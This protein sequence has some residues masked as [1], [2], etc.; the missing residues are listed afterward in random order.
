MR[1]AALAVLAASLPLAPSIFGPASAQVVVPQNSFHAVVNGVF[2]LCPRLVEAKIA[3][4]D[5]LSAGNWGFKPLE[6]LEPGEQRLQGLYTEAVVQLWFE[7]VQK[8]CTVHYGGA[9]YETIAIMVREISTEQLGYTS[10]ITENDRGGKVEILARLSTDGTMRQ[11][12]ILLEDPNTR[13]IAVSYN[14]KPNT[15]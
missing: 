11:E 1:K 13:S 14:E 15:Q 8:Q 12:Y 6:A 10:L 2:D 5:Q 3:F 9:G 7:R 4:P